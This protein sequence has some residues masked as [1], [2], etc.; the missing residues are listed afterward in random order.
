M[1]FLDRDLLFL[2]DYPAIFRFPLADRTEADR[3]IT[4]EPW[5][6][7]QRSTEQGRPLFGV[8]GEVRSKK[9]LT[10]PTL[11]EMS[12]YPGAFNRSMQHHLINLL[13]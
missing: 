10:G 9:D 5:S 3:W 1:S 6:S 7:K 8:T 2:L 4:S 13:F 11:L 12:D